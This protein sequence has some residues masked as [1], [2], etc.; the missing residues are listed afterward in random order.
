M[1]PSHD[2]ARPLSSSRLIDRVFEAAQHHPAVIPGLPVRSTLK[3]VADAPD[4]KQSDRDPVSDILGTTA[5]AQSA[6]QRVKETVD[7]CHL[8]EAQT[9]QVF[10]R[11]LLERAYIQIRAPGPQAPSL[12][13]VTDDAG[14]IEHLG[15]A[16]YV[17]PG[18]P[19]N[20][21]IT[22]QQDM[23]LAEIVLT[24]LEQDEAASMARRRLFLDDDD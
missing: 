5:D 2:A 11:A 14:L 22:D 13:G 8:V 1:W 10:E 12:E 7:R 19:M 23:K 20:W 3:R 9:P 16:V 4:Q 17:V 6:S 15:E 21:K 18:E 24:A